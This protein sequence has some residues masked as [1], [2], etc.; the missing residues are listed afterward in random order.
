MTGD[1]RDAACVSA[2]TD[3]RD[4]VPAAII[5]AGGTVERLG[6]PVEPGNLI[7]MGR[8]GRVLVIGLPGCAR[9]PKRNG[10]DWVL[11][12]LF[13]GIDA[14]AGAIAGMGVGGLLADGARPEPRPQYQPDA[15]AGVVGAL[16][17]AAG[18]SV[19]MGANKLTADLAG[20]PVL[21]HVLAAVD[22]A[23]LPAIVVT[24]HDADAVAAIAAPR[25]IVHA[26]RYAEGLSQTL[27]AGIRAV[28]ADWSAAVVVLG[29]MPALTATDLAAIAE[30]ASDDAIVVPV[31]DGK[32]GN[33][34]AWGRRFFGRLGAIEGDVGG[35]ALLAEFSDA[36]VE[37][38]ASGDGILV[39]V[40]TPEALAALRARYSS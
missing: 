14:G 17:L 12:R 11:E 31:H 25:A 28:P 22:A 19:R 10:V 9:S 38:E 6:M 20:R 21:S 26:A 3:R 33:P 18:R 8:V 34:V 27:A 5:A 35:K 15:G 13:A 23:R 30:R 7:C 16:V 32:R 40:D 39:D 4:V 1:E 24:G 2:I 29:D 36:V 37:V